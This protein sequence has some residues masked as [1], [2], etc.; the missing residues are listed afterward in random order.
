MDQ[1]K[2]RA[3]SSGISAMFMVVFTVV[4]LT[5]ISL[6]M[7]QMSAELGV[8]VGQIS[9]AL[10]IS[11]IGSFV[12]SMLIGTLM[13]KLSSKALVL[14]G[15]VC[16]AAF[17]LSI[18]FSDNIMIIYVMA[19]VNGF[20]S[21]VGGM[22][23]SQI[24]ITMWFAKGQGMMMSVSVVIMGLALTVGIPVV[25]GLVAEFGYRAVTLGMALVC[26]GG[27]VVCALL[28]SGA[29][30][31]YGLL[32]LGAQEKGAKGEEDAGKA[33]AIPPSL[34]WKRIAKTPMYWAIWVAVL[35]VALACQ[36]VTS[37]GAVVLGS[38]GLEPTQ[39]A[40]ALSVS[41]FVGMFSKL[42]FGFV[43]DKFS[44]KFG[45]YIF[46]GCYAVILL[47]SFI[48]TGWV[49][50]I[51]FAFGMGMGGCVPSLYGPNAAPRIFGPKDSGNMI[52]FLNMAS[53]LGATLG[54]IVVGMMYDA[55]GNYNAALEVLGVLLV[56]CLALN[57][58]VYS[59]GSQRK[60]Q[61]L[62]ALEAADDRADAAAA[63]E[64]KEEQ[65]S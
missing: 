12:A 57:W 62:I 30:Q 22:A 48:L 9:L 13:K 56:V 61:D 60:V 16:V 45:M 41:T 53:S 40:L 50:A 31:K 65:A 63:G 43:S 39:A 37:Q 46:A 3:W 51:I 58:W 17:Q 20:G 6:Y 23:M 33:A 54:P 38:F 7:Q 8:T 4:P 15:A 64:L 21:V 42:A 5:V 52:G 19:L 29:P 1:S 59:K 55:F 32:P 36:G 34:S 26:G 25:G 18:S 11:T 47:V 24:T 10:S 2:T 49:G 14:I 27:L 28:V 44:P 35:F